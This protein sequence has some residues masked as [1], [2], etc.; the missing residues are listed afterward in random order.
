M[1]YLKREEIF[2]KDYLSIQDIQDLLGLGY[3]DAAKM[4]REIKRS[5]AL[6]GKSVRLNI[7]GKLHT[8]EYF[9]YFGIT[10]YER[11]IPVSRCTEEKE[12]IEKEVARYEI[13]TTPNRKGKATE[14]TC[15]KDRHG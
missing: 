7:Q 11:Y 3:D 2:S 6:H 8:Q 12:K 13:E 4:I 15:Q 5:F 1:N 10:N 9:D 14:R